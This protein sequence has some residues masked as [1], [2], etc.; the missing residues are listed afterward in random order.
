M[1]RNGIK[2]WQSVPEW[3]TIQG[4]TVRKLW[5]KVERD[6]RSVQQR[7]SQGHRQQSRA[8]ISSSEVSH[9]L[10][11]SV[12][13][14]TQLRTQVWEPESLS[15]TPPLP[16]T[17]YGTLNTLLNC[18]KALLLMNTSTAFYYMDLWWVKWGTVLNIW[19]S[20]KVALITITI[21]AV[22]FPLAQVH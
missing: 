17:S 13:L 7:L 21:I 20:C 19:P 18:A 16:T 5:F 1:G 6:K 12:S 15:K 3:A 4:Y 9:R 10:K 11:E 14:S 2:G 8:Q 22:S